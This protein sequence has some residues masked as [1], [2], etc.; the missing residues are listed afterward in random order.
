MLLLLLE[1]G[2]SDTHPSQVPEIWL[3]WHP[4]QCQVG[5]AT[6]SVMEQ[7][8][9]AGFMGRALRDRAAC[10]TSWREPVR[11]VK[12]GG[13][14]AGGTAGLEFSLRLGIKKCVRDAKPRCA[15]SVVRVE[16]LGPALLMWKHSALSASR[17][18]WSCGGNHESRRDGAALVFA[19]T[20]D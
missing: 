3:I 20:N 19:E 2:T 14:A 8:A 16:C 12:S 9:F 15:P 10:H 13:D 4:S 5:P 1:Y 17:S 18:A 6:G 7:E 11:G